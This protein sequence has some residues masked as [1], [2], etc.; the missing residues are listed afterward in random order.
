MMNSTYAPRDIKFVVFGADG[1]LARRK[2]LP[3]F[4]KLSRQG[5]LPEN[6]QILG[7]GLSEM[8]NADFRN[9][10]KTS[11]RTLAAD[12]PFDEASW[13]RFA[14]RLHY[15]R[16]DA[17]KSESVSQIKEGLKK[18]NGGPAI[19]DHTVFY[20][21]TPPSIYGRAVES[22]LANGLAERKAGDNQWPKLVLEKP[23]GNGLAA[24]ERLDYLL[25]GSFS[26][27]QIYRVDHY[28][29]KHSVENIFALRFLD[30]RYEHLW[31]RRFIKSIRI[32]VAETDGVGER[33]MF[34]DHDGGALRD[35]VQS[36][37][38]QLLSSLLMEKPQSLVDPEAI[39][40]EKTS[41]LQAL[42]PIDRRHVDESVVAG[43]Y[44][45]GTVGENTLLGYRQERNVAARST[46]ETFAAMK[47]FVDTETWNGVPIFMCTGKRLGGR[48]G[49]VVVKF[50]KSAQEQ[51]AS[52][53]LPSLGDEKIASKTPE[54]IVFHI[55][56]ET[57]ISVRMQEKAGSQDKLQ[58]NAT[59]LNSS[60]AIDAGAETGYENIILDVARGNR[61]RFTSSAFNRAS[62]RFLSPILDGM[63]HQQQAFP[64]Y[65]AGSWGPLEAR[66]L[67]AN[68]GNR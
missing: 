10:A 6:F 20:L 4:Y 26:E 46:V 66:R 57:H 37:L 30:G 52:R 15:R 25:Q 28:L 47:V 24:A 49:Y 43:Q 68:A 11:T 3:T 7:A 67:L 38:L 22:L 18:L 64:N 51:A 31:N 33:A 55:H 35:M 60:A 21:S 54:A 34:Y 2:G 9:M 5:R 63:G 36:H 56:P 42:R 44:G 58:L 53:I 50:F 23:F 1:D 61:S 39:H 62:W 27:R 59:D 17:C 13:E 29:G 48:L 40:A 32:V 19:G 16:V 65:R 41:I 45:P 12:L 14:Q 8:T